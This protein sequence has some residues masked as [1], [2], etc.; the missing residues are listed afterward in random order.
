MYG[1]RA[2]IGFVSPPLMTELVPYEFYQMV[3]EGVGLLVTCMGLDDLTE[4]Q[5]AQALGTIERHIREQNRRGTDYVVVGGTPLILSRAAGFENE[6]LARLRSLSR[7]P[8]TTTTHSALAALSSLRVRR[9]VSLT[10]YHPWR[11]GRL[12]DFLAQQGFEALA[13][14]GFSSHI[15]DIHNI[16]P[17]TVFREAKKLFLRHP[18]A[19]AIY[20]PCAQLHTWPVIDV[21][22]KECGVPVVTSTLSWVWSALQELKITAPPRARSRL[23]E[24]TKQPSLS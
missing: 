6:F 21:L 23:L 2:R 5:M 1:W 4:E 18:E 16:A 11:N 9:L 17:E 14:E 3:P 24:T 12:R 13:V 10:T 7:V 19:Q 22:E 8:V 15:A 20:I